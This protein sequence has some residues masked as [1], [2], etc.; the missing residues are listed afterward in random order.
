MEEFGKLQEFVPR[1]SPSKSKEE[2]ENRAKE[3]H[4]KYKKDHEGEICEYRKGYNKEHS[5]EIKEYHKNYDEEH[6]EKRK[7][8]MKKHNKKYNEEHKDEIKEYN[9]MHK[10]KT[11][12]LGSFGEEG[13]SINLI[14]TVSRHGKVYGIGS[15]PN[16]NIHTPEQNRFNTMKRNL[17]GA[18]FLNESFPGSE[19][20]HMSKDVVIFIPKELH[21]SVWHNLETGKNMD[22]INGKALIWAG[23]QANG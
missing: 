2:K 14:Q 7:K 22:E 21:Q 6:S 15:F 20:H 4:K 23:R 12:I 8:Y 17:K 18:T 1:R 19:V 3:Y 5:E 9:K 16:A 10:G 11:V 13:F